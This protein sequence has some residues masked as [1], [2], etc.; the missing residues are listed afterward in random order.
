MNVERAEGRGRRRG[1]V[2]EA[3]Q[4]IPDLLALEIYS[5]TGDLRSG[6]RK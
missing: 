5:E 6:E 2:G 1:E 3:V 4:E